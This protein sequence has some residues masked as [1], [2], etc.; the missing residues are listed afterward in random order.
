M[1]KVLLIGGEGYIGNVLSSYLLKK[2]LHVRSLDLLIYDNKI[3]VEKKKDI[4][5]YEFIYGDFRN[6]QV[7]SE[8]LNEVEVVVLLAGLVGDPITKKYPEQSKQINYKGIQDAI[9]IISTNKNIKKFIFVSTCSNYGVLD[10]N[11]KANEDTILNPVSDYSL[12]KVEAEKLIIKTHDKSKENYILRFATAFGYSDR[13]RFDLT[14]NEFTRELYLKNKLIIFDKNS[15]RPYC[16]TYDFANV[17][18]KLIDT[19]SLNCSLK[20]LNVGSNSNNYTKNDIVNLLSKKFKNIDIDFLDKGIDTRNYM[21]SFNKLNNIFPNLKFKSI[22]EGMD[23]IIFYLRNNY[24]DNFTK[25]I[26]F[27]GNYKINYDQ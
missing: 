19:E 8:S 10:E 11:I 9:T 4:K 13:M 22:E 7:L 6:S 2:G 25:N 23:E 15:W 20:I 17:I 16:H 14:V 24:F 21:V 5:N 12:A 27:Y 1:S 26:N 3:C 18:F